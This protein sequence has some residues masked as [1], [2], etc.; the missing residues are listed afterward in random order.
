M[1]FFFFAVYFFTFLL[2][3]HVCYFFVCTSCTISYTTNNKNMLLTGDDNAEL[4]DQSFQ[5]ITTDN[6]KSARD[7]SLVRSSVRV[8]R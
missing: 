8:T 7:D 6:M 4:G 2:S 3:C 5:Y 1:Y